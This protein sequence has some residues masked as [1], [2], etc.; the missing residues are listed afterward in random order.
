MFWDQWF[1]LSVAAA[2]PTNDSPT[3]KRRT[4]GLIVQTFREK[5]LQET[6]RLVCSCGF[7]CRAE[8]S[9]LATCPGYFVRLRWFL[10]LETRIQSGRLLLHPILKMQ[11]F[12]KQ[13]DT[14]TLWLSEFQLL[15]LHSSLF[16]FRSEI[17]HPALNVTVNSRISFPSC[18]TLWMWKRRLWTSNFVIFLQI[19]W[20]STCTDFVGSLFF[21]NAEVR[22]S[23][24]LQRMY[25]ELWIFDS[26][27]SFSLLVLR[28][29]RP[30]STTFQFPP[31]FSEMLHPVPVG[32]I[33]VSGQSRD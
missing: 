33:F 15:H 3:D 23:V 5:W 29:N 7:A 24:P 19:F 18:F 14:F 12:S 11:E 8:R 16:C 1:F 31:P 2:G 4:L 30:L 27:E 26:P 17:L 32:K 22:W 20:R 9:D 10:C 6:L 21:V 13:T 28:S 25:L